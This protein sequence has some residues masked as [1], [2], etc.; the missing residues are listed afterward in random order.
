V[1][2]DVDTPKPFCSGGPNDFVHLSGPVRFVLTSYVDAAGRYLR[3]YQIDGELTVT[4]IGFPPGP[5][6]QAVVKERHAAYLSN[7]HGELYELGGQR[8][9]SDPPQSLYW[10]LKAGDYDAFGTNTQCGP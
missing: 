6:A 8:L 10:K 7:H 2:Y 4:P 1:E 3:Y 9:L 5:E